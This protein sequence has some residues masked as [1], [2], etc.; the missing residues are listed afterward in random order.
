MIMN[1]VQLRKKIIQQRKSLSPQIWQEKSNSI[2]NNLAKIPIFKKANV[3]LAYFPINQEPNLNSLFFLNK[4]WGFPRCVKK[5]LQW[6]LWQP[7]EALKIGKY[8]I[9]TPLPTAPKIESKEVD[10][11][12]VPS[13]ACDYNGYRLGYGGG[14]YDR[15]SSSSQWCN[16]PKIGIVFNNAYLPQLPV[17]PWDQKLQGVCTEFGYHQ[18]F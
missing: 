5:Q 13:V 16:I 18:H 10:L 1:K 17:D 8:G 11:I 4:K 14:Y 7:E 2:C 6:H 3:V 15:L 9:K 12:L